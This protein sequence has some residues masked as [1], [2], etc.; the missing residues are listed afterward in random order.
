MSQF[1]RD[2]G[3]LGQVSMYFAAVPPVQF[4]SG[5]RLGVLS[6]P[7]HCKDMGGGCQ[8]FTARPIDLPTPHWVYHR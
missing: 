6:T 4:A 3:G 8:S 7:P 2:G 1:A 5:F